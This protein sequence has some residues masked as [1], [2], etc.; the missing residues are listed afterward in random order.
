MDKEQLDAFYAESARLRHVA[1][2]EFQERTHGWHFE[3]A[4]EA[5]QWAE[6]HAAGDHWSAGGSTLVERADA[7]GMI[8]KPEPGR[9]SSAYSHRDSRTE[10]TTH[11]GFG[12]WPDAA[13]A[14]IVHAGRA[15]PLDALE[16]PPARGDGAAVLTTL[17]LVVETFATVQPVSGPPGAA[18]P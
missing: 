17:R 3:L 15:I 7:A 4:P 18:R 14:L 10:E 12:F 16:P 5:D 6:S 1:E 13:E 2:R 11:T 9:I 8:R